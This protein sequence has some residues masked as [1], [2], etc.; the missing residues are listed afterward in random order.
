M[1]VTK[2]YLVLDLIVVMFIA[3]ISVT[4]CQKDFHQVD[5]I[6]LELQDGSQLTVPNLFKNILRRSSWKLFTCQNLILLNAPCELHLS[7]ESLF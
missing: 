2:K 4:P 7:S 6:A 5:S 1:V 3:V